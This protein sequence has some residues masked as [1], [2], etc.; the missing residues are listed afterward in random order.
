M[1]AQFPAA[2]PGSGGAEQVYSP[3]P[4][5]TASALGNWGPF[6]SRSPTI[7]RLV[8]R[9]RALETQEGVLG[10]PMEAPARQPTRTSESRPAARPGAANHAAA[11]GGRMGRSLAPS[12]E[13]RDW[14]E[15]GPGLTIRRLRGSRPYEECPCGGTATSARKGRRWAGRSSPRG[16]VLG[17]MT[18][19]SVEPRTVPQVP[20]CRPCKHQQAGPTDAVS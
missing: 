16:V 20:G 19:E 4:A 12:G 14:E 9:E 8:T 11:R 2:L 18:R 5:E 3:W 1:Q 7:M 15:A 6:H 10:D 13:G 17:L